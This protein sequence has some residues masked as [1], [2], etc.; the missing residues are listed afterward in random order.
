MIINHAELSLKKVDN[1]LILIKCARSLWRNN[2]K[3]ETRGSYPR[4]II[5]P[6]Y[7]ISL[8][9]HSSSSNSGLQDLFPHM[10]MHFFFFFFFQV[11]LFHFIYTVKNVWTFNI[12]IAYTFSVIRDQEHE[13]NKLYYYSVSNSGLI[14]GL[15]RISVSNPLRICNLF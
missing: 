12:L 15:F 8:Y 4:R 11:F 14:L 7:L 13:L 9:D 6:L 5:L 1:T 2:S 3:D 10:P